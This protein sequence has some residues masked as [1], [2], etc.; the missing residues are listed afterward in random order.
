MPSA[1]YLLVPLPK[2]PYSRIGP[3]HWQDYYRQLQ[4]TVAITRNLQKDGKRVFIAIL[5]NFHPQGQLSEIEIYTKILAGL[6]P[7]LEVRSYQETNDTAGQVERSFEL[8][9]ELNAHLIFISTWMHY[10]RV[11]YL[12]QRRSADHYG[13]FGIPQPA[14][15]FIDPFCLFFQ[16]IGDLL[17]VSNYFRNF[18][19]H[20]REKGKIL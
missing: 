20:Q 2:N 6:A 16:P 9:E 19:I 17:G 4:R 12:A 11:R 15:A 5:S 8:A 18:V 13:A 14:F 1:T 10:P 3:L 7:E